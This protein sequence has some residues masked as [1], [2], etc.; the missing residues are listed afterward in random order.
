[1]AGLNAKKA[2]LAQYNRAIQAAVKELE[3]ARRATFAFQPSDA[4][5]DYNAL[6]DWKVLQDTLSITKAEVHGLRSN[7]VVRLALAEYINE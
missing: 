1:M 7:A 5:E 4:L 6:E 2:A 3:A